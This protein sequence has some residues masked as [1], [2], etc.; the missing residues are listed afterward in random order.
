MPVDRMRIV[1][2]G[3]YETGSSTN[4]VR[5]LPFRIASCVSPDV[6]VERTRVLFS[7]SWRC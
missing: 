7:H 1:E 6:T 2:T 3:T 4:F 5:V